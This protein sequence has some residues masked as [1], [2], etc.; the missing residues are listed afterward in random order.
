[1][2]KI[3]IILIG[4]LGIVAIYKLWGYIGYARAIRNDAQRLF[5]SH[6]EFFKSLEFSGVIAEKK[7]CSECQLNK[8][9]MVVDLREKKP[10]TIEFGN[11]SYPP[12]Y[13]FNG[14]NQLTIS[15]TMQIYNAAEKDSSI[16]K[17][18]NSDSLSLPGLKCRLL[19]DQK[20]QWIAQ[21]K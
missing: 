16:K 10:D 19:S 13:F 5:V 21:D 18:V 6:K 1:M 14:T 20:M 15:V 12:Y 9:E 11:L 17:E 2:K 7:Y 8:Y 3:I 4:I